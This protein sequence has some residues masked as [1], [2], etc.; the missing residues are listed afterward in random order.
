MLHFSGRDR[1]AG[2]EIAFCG[3]PFPADGNLAARLPK[4]HS[5]QPFLGSLGRSLDESVFVMVS[6]SAVPNLGGAYARRTIVGLSLP[7]RRNLCT[8]SP[9]KTSPVLRM[10]FEFVASMW[11][12]KNCPPF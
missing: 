1:P 8:R 11:S 12:P 9:L 4:P 7:I 10:P 6:K 3:L 2:P 5:D